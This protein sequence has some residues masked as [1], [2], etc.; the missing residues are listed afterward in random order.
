M[1]YAETALL[2]GER[3]QETR[4][5]DVETCNG[6]A[7]WQAYKGREYVFGRCISG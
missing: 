5:N 7:F 4:H 3:G 2:T 6:M 1:V